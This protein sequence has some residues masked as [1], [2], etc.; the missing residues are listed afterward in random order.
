MKM[1]RFTLAVLGMAAP[2]MLAACASQEFG[3]SSS[4][5]GKFNLY[6]CDQLNRRGAELVRRERELQGLMEKAAQGPG[7]EVAIAIAYRSEYNVVQG[8]L[9]EIERVGAEKKCI[10]KHRVVSDQIVR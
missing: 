6:N 9:F 5:P 7:G 8:D 1:T 2:A 10:M 3:I 4:K